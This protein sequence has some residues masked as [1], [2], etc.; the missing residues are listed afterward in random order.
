MAACRNSL[1]APAKRRECVSDVAQ[2]DEG[3]VAVNEQLTVPAIL[4]VFSAAIEHV[5]IAL[6]LTL[7]QVCDILRH[8]DNRGEHMHGAYYHGPLTTRS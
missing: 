5:E 4:S 7:H 8:V 1:E 3:L 6:W 2:G